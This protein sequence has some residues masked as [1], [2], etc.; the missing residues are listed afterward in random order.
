MLITHYKLF[1]KKNVAL[2][3]ADASY[4]IKIVNIPSMPPMADKR[5]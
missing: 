3:A 2:Q 4:A 1:L 5:G